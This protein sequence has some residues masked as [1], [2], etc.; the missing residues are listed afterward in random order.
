MTLEI[1][2]QNS[3]I[4]TRKSSLFR[5][6]LAMRHFCETTTR[7]EC[8]KRAVLAHSVLQKQPEG[9]LKRTPRVLIVFCLNLQYFVGANF[10]N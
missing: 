8:E 1:L 7:L 4:C 5:H 9:L 10:V 2:V 3:Y 6:G